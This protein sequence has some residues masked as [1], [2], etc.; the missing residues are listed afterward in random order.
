MP[1]SKLPDLHHVSDMSAD[2]KTPQSK[3][4]RFASCV[5]YLSTYRIRLESV[6]S[7]IYVEPVSGPCRIRVNS[8][9]C[10]FKQ[11]LNVCEQMWTDRGFAT[12]AESAEPWGS[13]R[14]Y[15]EE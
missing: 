13:L 11:I 15:P 6:Q 7:R 14:L 5:G 10:K 2:T 9:Y 8:Q 12:V 4:L 3:L 1:Q